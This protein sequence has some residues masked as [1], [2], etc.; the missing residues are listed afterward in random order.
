MRPTSPRISIGPT[1]AERGQ[2]NGLRLAGFTD[3][4]HFLT[5]IISEFPTVIEGEKAKRALQALLHPEM[6]GRAFQALALSEDVD[7]AKPLAGFKFERNARA[8]LGL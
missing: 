3:Q 2:A 7:L 1:I 4:H 5:G 8:A 6:L